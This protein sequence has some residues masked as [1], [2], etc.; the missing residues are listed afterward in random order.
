MHFTIQN[1]ILECMIIF[2]CLVLTL[3]ILLMILIIWVQFERPPPMKF[4]YIYQIKHGQKC[5]KNYS[6]VVFCTP[7][8][9]FAFSE[10]I[11]KFSSSPSCFLVKIAVIWSHGSMLSTRSNWDDTVCARGSVNV[12]RID[13]DKVQQYTVV[14]MRTIQQTEDF[15]WWFRNSIAM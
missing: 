2:S 5:T 13:I 6:V 14:N 11:V 15:K 1:K 10:M 12:A 3:M 4:F 7:N 8:F 9:L